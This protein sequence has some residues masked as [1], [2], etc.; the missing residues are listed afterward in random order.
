MSVLSCYQPTILQVQS[1]H[2]NLVMFMS[3]STH[4][5]N[6]NQRSLLT[7]TFMYIIW[8]SPYNNDVVLSSWSGGTGPSQIIAVQAFVKNR[9][10]SQWSELVLTNISLN[11][12]FWCK[13]LLCSNPQCKLKVSDV[14]RI[15]SDGGLTQMGAK[16]TS[17]TAALISAG[18][19]ALQYYQTWTAQWL[20]LPGSL[21]Q[22]QSFP[23]EWPCSLQ[24]SSLDC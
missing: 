20:N 2:L 3:S 18:V 21:Q 17:L 8:L 14:M 6:N 1:N 9:I 13:K 16:L 11:V 10:S 12:S 23:D 19:F 15:I 24:E 22:G 4:T 5:M 7:D